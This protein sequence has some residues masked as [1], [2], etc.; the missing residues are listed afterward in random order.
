MLKV[1]KIRVE[2]D[3]GAIFAS[4]ITSE[5]VTLKNDQTVSFLILSGAGTEATPT[6][7]IMAKKGS[8]GDAVAVD[9]ILAEVGDDTAVVG[10]ASDGQ[11]IT[12]GGTAGSLPAYIATITADM[13]AG[14]G[15]DTVYATVTKVTSSTVPGAIVAITDQPRYAE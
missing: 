13:L 3:P 14:T 7:K 10:G 6:L 2:S 11:A 1:P 12:I 8:S 9:F 5:D 4:A 15:Y